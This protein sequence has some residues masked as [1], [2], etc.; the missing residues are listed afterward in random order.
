MDC[1]NDTDEDPVKGSLRTPVDGL[2]TGI[3]DVADHEVG[4]QNHENRKCVSPVPDRAIIPVPPEQKKRY[5]RNDPSRSGNRTAP[6]GLTAALHIHGFG[7]SGNCRLPVP[8][9]LPSTSTTGSSPANVPVANA[10]SAP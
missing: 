4:Q 3:L 5:R 2:E 7:L 6:E 1:D 8:M 10:S 9:R